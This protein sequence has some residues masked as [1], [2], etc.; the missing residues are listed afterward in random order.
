MG[1]PH[2]AE[3]SG[4]TLVLGPLKTPVP[5][6]P[7]GVK[8]SSISTT[9]PLAVQ[10]RCLHSV[11]GSSV[12]VQGLHYC[13]GDV[14][15][16]AVAMTNLQLSTGCSPWPLCKLSLCLLGPL[17]CLQHIEVSL[18]HAEHAG[19]WGDGRGSAA[20]RMSQH[21]CLLHYGPVHHKAYFSF[22]LQTVHAQGYAQDVSP[23]L[24]RS[25]S[26]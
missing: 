16:V 18:K 6:S 14:C 9:E 2:L 15:S 12:L 24:Q 11:L 26:G 1:Q 8:R 19:Q 4:L 7:V 25:A 17:G 3:Q 22:A 5:L 20:V 13:Q 21:C 10:L 23:I